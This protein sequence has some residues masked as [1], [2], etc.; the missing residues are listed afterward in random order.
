MGLICTLF[1]SILKN[2]GLY[3]PDVGG[4]ATYSKLLETELPKHDMGVSVLSFDS[5]RHFPKIIRH[6]VY[7]FKL[8]KIGRQ[9]DIIFAQDPVSVGFPAMCAAKLLNKKFLLKV[10]GDYAWEQWMQKKTSA[11]EFVTPDEFQTKR[12]GPITELRRTTERFV[13]RQAHFVIV[14][15]KYLKHILSLWGINEKKIRVVY[16][17]FRP[18]TQL[19]SK[20][21]IREMLHFHGTLVVSVGRLVPW[22]GFQTLMELMPHLS[23]KYP[24]IRLMIIGDGPDLHS[25]QEHIEKHGLENKVVLTGALPQDVLFSYI[26]AADIFI[27][28][29]LYEGFSHALLEA[30]AFGIPIVT[31]DVGGNPEIIQNNKNGF[32]VPYNDKKALEKAL[33]RILENPSLKNTIANNSKNKVKEFSEEKM[34][35][36]LIPILRQFS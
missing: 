19:G 13:A 4:P 18:P 16:N 7:F 5:V 20:E 25:L 24:D 6:I 14:P 10:V 8:L 28:N 33:I 26:Q 12:Y 23:R 11:K 3:P 22:K 1:K 30:S 35:Q 34:I 31:T 27:L 21:I 9:A 29:T 15:S 17:G 2:T 36:T 32:L